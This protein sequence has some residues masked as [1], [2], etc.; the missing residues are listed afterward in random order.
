MSAII[1]FP[2]SQPTRSTKSKANGTKANPLATQNDRVRYALLT[3]KAGAA[4]LTMDELQGLFPDGTAEA[5]CVDMARGALLS[6]FS[7]A[8]R[9]AYP[10]ER[11]P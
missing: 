8:H 5:A 4:M 9:R 1:V 2:G 6:L 7:M 11:K 10:E 3:E